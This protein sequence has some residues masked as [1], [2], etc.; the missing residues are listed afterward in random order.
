VALRPLAPVL[1]R[2]DQREHY[3]AYRVKNSFYFAM[4]ST[5]SKNL[6]VLLQIVLE[7]SK[8]ALRIGIACDA[9]GAQ[10]SLM[11]KLKQRGKLM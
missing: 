7:L 3:M 11:N 2:G 1:V 5:I 8:E 6:R 10:K 9:L 4:K